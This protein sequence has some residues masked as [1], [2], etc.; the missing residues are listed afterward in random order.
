GEDVVDPAP[1]D[2]GSIEERQGQLIVLEPAARGLEPLHHEPVLRRNSDRAGDGKSSESL[3]PFRETWL[4]GSREEQEGGT[5]GPRLPG[6]EAAAKDLPHRSV[7]LLI[8]RCSG[9]APVVTVVS[10]DTRHRVDVVRPVLMVEDREQDH[11]SAA[12]GWPCIADSS[13]V[14]DREHVVDRL[15]AVVSG[16]AS[17]VDRVTMQ[18]GGGQI[19]EPDD[20]RTR[21]DRWVVGGHPGA[22]AAIAATYPSGIGTASPIHLD[23][24]AFEG[25]AP[26]RTVK[27]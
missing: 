26:R 20:P 12:V 27:S 3:G 6:C 1:R 22:R 9:A 4:V 21:H 15:V 23:N 10:D 13:L 17:L 18:I 16:S 25:G 11:E 19:G 14:A 24:F 7:A 2:R 8:E 5:L